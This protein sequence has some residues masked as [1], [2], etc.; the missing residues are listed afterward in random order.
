MDI[1]QKLPLFF[2]P[3]LWSYIFEKCDPQKMKRTIIVQALNYGNL[4]HWNWIRS[5]YGE[6]EIRNIL[7]SLFETE[8]VWRKCSFLKED[9]YLAGGTA[10]ALQI[11]HRKS[12]DLDFFSN[13]PIKSD[14]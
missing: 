5:Y 7:S 2:K 10:L 4:S 11:G 12:I 13:Q 3:I 8:Q 14:F 1:N 9:F 6:E